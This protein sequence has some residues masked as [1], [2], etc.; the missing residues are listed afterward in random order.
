MDPTEGTVEQQM[1]LGAGM[2]IVLVDSVQVEQDKAPLME[3]ASRAS[4]GI[5]PLQA[6]AELVQC[7]PTSFY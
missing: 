2:E 1:V 7:V 5:R 6:P 4:N 3:R